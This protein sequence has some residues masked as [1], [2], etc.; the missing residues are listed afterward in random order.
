MAHWSDAYMDR[1]WSEDYNCAALAV[2]VAETVFRRSVIAPVTAMGLRAG[3]RTIDAMR[4]DIAERV[5]TPTDGDVVLMQ[6]GPLWHV[7]VVAIIGARVWV[8]HNLKSTG[9]VVRTEPRDLPSLGLTM[10]G[11]YR[12]K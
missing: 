8:L 2:D 4:D 12:W 5:A 3:A 9:R 6:C 1:P 10:E 11:Y 7:G